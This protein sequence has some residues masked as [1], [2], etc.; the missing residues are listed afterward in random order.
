MQYQEFSNKELFSQILYPC[1]F[2]IIII[3]I[4]SLSQPY[5][6]QLHE[7]ILPLVKSYTEKAKKI[8]H[9]SL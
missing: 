2:I 6:G 9:K 5:W 4:K 3:I 1:P 8:T 7:S